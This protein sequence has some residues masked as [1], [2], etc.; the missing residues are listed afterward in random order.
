MPGGPGTMPTPAQAV[1]ALSTA[2]APLMQGTPPEYAP[3][4]AVSPPSPTATGS[5]GSRV[6][7]T[8]SGAIAPG[9]IT[10]PNG[11]PKMTGSAASNGS[12]APLPPNLNVQGMSTLA[13][14]AGFDPAMAAL[15]GQQVLAEAFRT[16]RLDA[17]NYHEMLAGTGPAAPLAS[18]AARYGH[19]LGL[20]G[21]L[22]S[23]Q[24]QA[25]AAITGH[26]LSADAQRDVAN[27]GQAGQDRRFIA[28]PT[29][30]TTDAQGNPLASPIIVTRGEATKGRGAYDSAIAQQLGAPGTFFDPNSADPSKPIALTI[31]EGIA[32][33][34]MPAPASQDAFSAGLGLAYSQEKDPVKRQELL[35]RMTGISTLPKG[36]VAAKEADEQKQVDYRVLQK[37]YPQP[38]PYKVDLQI[39]DPVA[40]TPDAESAVSDRVG[41]L[42]NT[43]RRLAL[44]KTEAREE[45]IRQLQAEGTLYTPA[46]IAEARRSRS[47]L[48]VSVGR[49]IKVDTYT[50]I[51]KPASS[52]MMIGLKN[53]PGA[54]AGGGGGGAVPPQVPAGMKDIG[55]APPGTPDG[56]RTVKGK[57]AFY[58]GGRV[59]Q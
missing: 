21:T 58:L 1:S 24:I 31:G 46:E 51:G 7:D 8:V 34:L 49:D 57:P 28:E 25:G 16:G 39:K 40:L 52:H 5:D 12:P 20:K 4:S 27:I 55:A 44:N 2:M 33:R 23:A 53:K 56:P 41:K 36:P 13:A 11:G 54:A 30:V 42:Q 22:G 29:T 14:A 26:K 45:A 18:D 47:L 38:D 15:F 59:Y 17:H 6:P 10:D 3:P 9:S 35:N 32:R 50:P 43:D 48:D 19:E 37:A